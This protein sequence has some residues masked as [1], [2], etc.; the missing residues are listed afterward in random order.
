[1]VQRNN[2][3]KIDLMLLDYVKDC[4]LDSIG[5]NVTIDWNAS[6]KLI[7]NE[8]TTSKNVTNGEDAG[9]SVSQNN[10]NNNEDTMLF[11]GR[12]FDTATL[13]SPVMQNENILREATR[14]LINEKWWRT[15][16]LKIKGTT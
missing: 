3:T 8:V 9:V 7:N 1:M 4:F 12:L 16:K 2:S 11:K 10:V 6:F 13:E 5:S 15:C 14:G